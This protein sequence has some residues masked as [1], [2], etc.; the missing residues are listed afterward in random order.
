[1]EM[2]YQELLILAYFK[3]HYKKYEFN[4][5]LKLMGMTY[6]E[7]RIVI[8]RLLEMNYLFCYENYIVITKIGEDILKDTRL[9][10]FYDNKNEKRKKNRDIDEPYVPI[11]FKI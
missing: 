9:E 11:N 7:L 1:M 10:R 8:E 3:S 6:A 5:I 4:E 2:K